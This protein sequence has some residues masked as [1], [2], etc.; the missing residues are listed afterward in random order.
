MEQKTANL[1]DFQHRAERKCQKTFRKLTNY[2]LKQTYDPSDKKKKIKDPSASKFQGPIHKDTAD[3]AIR[4]ISGR[5]T[6]PYQQI[7]RG[8]CACVHAR[9]FVCVCVKNN[10]PKPTNDAALKITLEFIEF[11]V[12]YL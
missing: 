3:T 9:V 4:K 8:V 10:G 2:K 6:A 12:N 1:D 5:G 11:K 7:K